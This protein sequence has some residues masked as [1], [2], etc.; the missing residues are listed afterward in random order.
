MDI[1]TNLFNLDKINNKS[2]IIE[3]FRRRKRRTSREEIPSRSRQD[4]NKKSIKNVKK[5]ESSGFGILSIL[6]IIFGLIITTFG[7]LFAWYKY[8]HKGELPSWIPTFLTKLLRPS[9]IVVPTGI[10]TTV[11]YK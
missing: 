6:G 2:N 1:L 10:P 5:D 7:G 9:G 11:K 4:E 8:G 3:E